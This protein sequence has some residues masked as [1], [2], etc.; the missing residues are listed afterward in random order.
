MPTKGHGERI[1]VVGILNQRFTKLLISLVVLVE[2]H[3]SNAFSFSTL[4]S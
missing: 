3:G 1:A 2:F 4:S